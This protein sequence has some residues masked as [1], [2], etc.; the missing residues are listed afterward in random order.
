LPFHLAPE[1]EECSTAE[2]TRKSPPPSHSKLKL[3]KPIQKPPRCEAR[4]MVASSTSSLCFLQN[5]GRT[6][7]RHK[8][9]MANGVAEV[10]AHVPFGVRV[11]NTSNQSRSL[12]KGIILGWALPHP[13]QILAVPDSPTNAAEELVDGTLS[14]TALPTGEDLT[15][16]TGLKVASKW[17]S[18]VNL[19]QLSES[20]RKAVL[21]MLEP[22]K[23]KWD[24]RLGEVSATKHRIDLVPGARPIHSLPYRAG[25]RAREIE[26]QEIDKMLRQ[27][28]IEPAMSEWASPIVMVPKPDGSLS[29]CVD[30]RKLNA[31]TVPD[32]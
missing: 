18:Q 7:E 5:S 22:H 16:E 14:Q 15:T 20:D 1:K 24:G 9:S 11:I 13:A 17:R 28:V 31:I 4:V 8:I 19:E 3:A 32:T 27:G 23:S 30:Y 29:F 12:P 21:E 6:H 10:Q 25:P 26:K 2:F